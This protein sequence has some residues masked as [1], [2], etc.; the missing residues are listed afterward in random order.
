M[1]SAQRPVVKPARTPRAAQ[2]SEQARPR[3]KPAAVRREE[4]LDAAER[5]FL[6]K[7]MAATSV[8]EIVTL[9]NVAK[10]TFYLHFASKEQLL[11]GLQDRFVNGFRVIVDKALAR[12][13][14]DDHRG[15][16]RTWLQTMMAYYLEKVALHD[17]VFHEYHPDERDTVQDKPVILELSE[18]IRAGVRDGAFDVDDPKLTAMMLFYALHAAA[19]VAVSK[20]LEG[21]AYKRH[22]AT[23]ESFVLRGVGSAPAQRS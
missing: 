3:T 9:A 17:L 19:D 11:L 15:R 4:L 22:L 8:D 18:M 1:S 6:D 7:G 20:K 2:P 13:K 23:L 14:P 12:R 5:L 21:A 16:L 10:G